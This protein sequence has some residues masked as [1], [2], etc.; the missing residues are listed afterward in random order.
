[1]KIN[2]QPFFNLMGT[3]LLGLVLISCG[4]K[5]KDNP[6]FGNWYGFEQDSTYY[7]LYINDTLIVL[8]HESIGPIGYDY[9]VQDNILIVSNAAGMER[10]WQMTA[11]EDDYFTLIDSLET[12]TYFKIDLAQDFFKSIQDSLS[13]VEFQEG[14]TFRYLEKKGE[15]VP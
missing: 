4:E 15:N 3:A 13:Y 14:F 2:F 9:F 10:V 12:I 6:L 11:V 7:E 1:M 8:N 5:E